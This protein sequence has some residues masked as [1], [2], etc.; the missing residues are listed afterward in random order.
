MFIA[1]V[2]FI[3]LAGIQIFFIVLRSVSLAAGKFLMRQSVREHQSQ[4]D[5]AVISSKIAEIESFPVGTAMVFT[6]VFLA[7]A[8]VFF[9]LQ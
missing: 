3:V 8:V 5:L 6:L 2:V 7:L 9:Y 1:G 4:E